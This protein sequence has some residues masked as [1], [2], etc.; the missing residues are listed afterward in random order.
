[1]A[2]QADTGFYQFD[3]LPPIRSRANDLGFKQGDE[4]FYQFDPL[5]PVIPQ[6]GQTGQTPGQPLN[7]GAPNDVWNPDNYPWLNMDQGQQGQTGM[8]GLG[9]GNDDPMLPRKQIDNGF[10]GYDPLPP[11]Q[12]RRANDLGSQ[13]LGNLAETPVKRR[14]YWTEYGEWIP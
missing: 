2:K 1:M 3:P 14:G 9:F 7:F 6:T 4:G 12:P 5:P 10:Y 11:V 8:T 13:T